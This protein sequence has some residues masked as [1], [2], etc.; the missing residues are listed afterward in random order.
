[1]NISGQ[2]GGQVFD[3]TNTRLRFGVAQCSKRVTVPCTSDR[4]VLL[5]CYWPLSRSVS[6]QLYQ[7]ADTRPEPPHRGRCAKR[8]TRECNGAS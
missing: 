3:G 6:P 8:V 5:R 4:Y 2:N 1:V 7:L